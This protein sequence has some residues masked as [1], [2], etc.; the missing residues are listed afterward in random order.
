MSLGV[1]TA[2]KRNEYQESSW[3]RGVKGRPQRKAENLIAICEP[4]VLKM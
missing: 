3:G 2:T 4:T 1:D